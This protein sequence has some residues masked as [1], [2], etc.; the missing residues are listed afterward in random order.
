MTKTLAELFDMPLVDI[1]ISIN[2][3]ALPDDVA[4]FLREA[5]L[6]VN[7]F[8]GDSPIRVTGFVPSG[9][10]TVYHALHAITKANLAPGTTFCEWGKWLRRGGVVSRDAWV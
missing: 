3:A 6:R 7:Q 8:V 9:F 1:E 2:G 5:D 4:A 10:V